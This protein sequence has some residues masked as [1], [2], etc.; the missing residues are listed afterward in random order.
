MSLV[1]AGTYFGQAALAVCAI[2]L[3]Y[4]LGELDTRFD[5]SDAQAKAAIAKAVSIWEEG[6][7][8]TLFEETDGEADVD[9]NFVFDERQQ[10]SDEERAFA[11]RLAD[12]KDANQTLSDMYDALVTEYEAAI[13]AYEARQTVY[14][15]NLRQ[16]NATVER[17][18]KDGGAPEEEFA[19]LEAESNRL[20]SVA[21]GLTNEASRLNEY[22]EEI[23]TL[24]S[25]GNEV[26]TNIN[27]NVAIYNGRFATPREFTQGDYQAGVI[28]I[29]TFETMDELVAVLVHE[30]G[31]A[32]SIPH[33]ENE[34]SMMYYL[35]E[36]QTSTLTLSDEDKAAFYQEC[37]DG[38]FWGRV[39]A[40]WSK[41]W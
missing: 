16:Y 31:H 13:A 22:V 17:Y 18:N 11:Q 24:S 35:M 20:A 2:P 1:F 19:K 8:L 29:Y 25:R 6:T 36:Q 21:S 23:N 28:H 3:S 39:Q 10:L 12:S 5:L 37:A 26:I 9:I 14:E 40:Q 27:N 7:G 34:R 4:R 30:L 15:R 41:I 32:L 33:V 38:T